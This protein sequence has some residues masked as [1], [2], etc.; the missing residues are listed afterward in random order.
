MTR[1]RADIILG[2][3]LHDIG[4]V[5]FRQGDD[6][7]KHGQ[8]GY[9]YLKEEI[10]ITDEDA[11]FLQCVRYHHADALRYSGLG[12]ES[13]AYIT[14][15]ADNIA[16]AADRR[17]ND[18]EEAGFEINTSLLSVF[19][20]LNGNDHDCYYIPEMLDPGMGINYPDEAKVP[21]TV[22]KYN[23]IKQNLTDNLKGLDWNEH[24]INSLLEVLE[25]NL[26]YVPSSTSKRER[27]D[28]SLYDHLKLT[29]ALSGAIYEYLADCGEKDYRQVLFTNGKEFY[30]KKAFVLYTLDMSGIQK[31]IYTISSKNAL[32]TLRVRSFYLEI[33][34]EHIIDSILNEAGLSRANVIYSGGGHCYL[35]LPNVNSIIEKA[36]RYIDGVNAWLVDKFDIS[37]YVAS[38]YSQCSANDL[39]NMP[40]GSYSDIFRRAGNMLS[41]K[42][43]CRYDADTLRMLNTKVDSDHTRECSV[44]RRIGKTN[45]SGRC[46][47]CEAIEGFSKEILNSDVF[48]VIRNDEKGTLPLPGDYSLTAGSKEKI[49]SMLK[50]GADIEH[51][52]TKNNQYTGTKVATRVWVADYRNGQTFEEFAKAAKGIDRIAVL[53]ADVDNLGQAFVA[54]FNNEK[55]DDRYVTLSRTACLSR[56]LSMFFK[57]HLN[58]I[59]GEPVNRALHTE[60]KRNLAVCYSGGDDLFIV[61]AWSDVIEASIDIR[62]CFERY[63]DG[64]L[65]ISAGIAVY[66]LDYPI[67]AAA[68]E[69]AELEEE[70]K[71][72][73]GK[74][75]ITILPDGEY[76]KEGEE[77][78]NDG[79]Y[80]WREFEER[81]IKEK[82]EC[83]EKFFD[84]SEERG[85]A[86]LYRILELIRNRKE[87]INFARC[88][89]MLSRLEPGK[90]AEP[91]EKAEYQA[92][93]KNIYRWI[94]N[95]K[96]SRE[97]KT[98]IN[99][100]VYMKREV[101]ENEDY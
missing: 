24:Y 64:M 68:Y 38:G 89:Y 47:I 88:V 57:L 71:H 9:D 99:I 53:R 36:E 2:G 15:M 25:A 74:A 79:T 45:D 43:G 39:K 46:M 42:K 12:S 96:D 100:Y 92:F 63:T 72:K 19:G 4:K 8:S 35:L 29:A 61:G 67:S 1:D 80:S 51:L 11:G 94:Q 56:Q 7:R 37:L 33:M 91:E 70:S 69:T 49:R 95:D 101:E 23:K 77:T 54:G 44:C 85:N 30:S 50:E 10:G 58:R 20:V 86:F 93:S 13:I 66:P 32:K 62:K 84:K 55:N 27:A 97:L 31:F 87:K 16:S 14:Y 18:S 78:I 5:I 83:I 73:S 21:F 22:D 52:Y 17:E 26:S 40:K 76:H 34:M 90:D 48:A 41:A 65:S 81:V 59:L 60:G 3:L 28:I 75:S 98:A 6:K 82:L